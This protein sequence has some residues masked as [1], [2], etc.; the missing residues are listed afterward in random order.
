VSSKITG[1]YAWYENGGLPPISS[2]YAT[3]C[4]Y[5]ES[6]IPIASPETPPPSTIHGSG[7]GRSPI[8]SSSPCTG[9]GVCASKR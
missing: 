5:Q 2:G 9:N 8:A 7:D 3:A 6:A 4:V 1:T